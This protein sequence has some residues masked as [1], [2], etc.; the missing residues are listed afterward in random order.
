VRHEHRLVQHVLTLHDVF[1]RLGVV[2][3]PSIVFASI[4]ELQVSD[5]LIGL[6]VDCL[7]LGTN[8]ARSL[9]AFF[10]FVRHGTAV[11]ARAFAVL[12]GSRA[13]YLAARVPR[14]DAL[15]GRD[16]LGKVLEPLMLQTGLTAV[17]IPCAAVSTQPTHEDNNNITY[18]VPWRCIVECEG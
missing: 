12:G 16:I 15:G 11:G 8:L 7:E 5:N 10:G 14:V 9:G 2:P 18:K 13:R 4:I 3:V 1:V 6:D 17:Q